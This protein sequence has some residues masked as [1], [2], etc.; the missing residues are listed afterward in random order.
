MGAVWLV[1][2]VELRRRWR[3][4]VILVILIAT[5]GGLVLAAAAA[6]RRTATAFPR[7]IAVHG[8]DVAAFN[9]R[10]RAAL[11]KLPEIASVTE[12]VSPSTGQPSCSCG[13]IDAQ[14]F[15]VVE[16]S[17]R[18]MHRA[19]KLEA[20]RWP[21]QSKPD[22]ALATYPLAQDLGV[23][24]GSVIRVPFYA[25][26]QSDAIDA[27]GE[28]P[29]PTGPKVSLRVVGIEAAEVD[30]PAGGTPSYS[31]YA[32]LS[33]AA[34]LTPLTV[35][36]TIDLVR[37][38]HGEGDL[39]RFNADAQPLVAGTL[40]LDAAAANVESSI[41]PQAVGWWVL[42][43]LVAM[44]GVA[45][46][47]QAIGRQSIVESEMYGTLL[48][49]GLPPRRLV[50]L[51]AVRALT[52]AL[53]GAVGAIVVAVALSPATPLG[54]ARVAEPSTGLAFDSLVL[55][56]GALS[57]VIVVIVLAVGPSIRAA[58]LRYVEERDPKLR[59][60]TDRHPA[61]GAGLAAFGDR[62]CASRT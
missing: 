35:T 42:A 4:W 22:E 46:V 6:G 55:L 10:S 24:V 28:L 56:L 57:I 34:K 18:A 13:R 37:L 21:D 25:A 62:R 54:E 51:V 7:F 60:S 31:L 20:G 36:N 26:S 48:A 11:V 14:E 12:S 40:N 52:V 29:S 39:P 32:T 58:R 59:P 23:H 16:M 61:C 33:L 19:L 47:G 38:R 50:A 17:S 49:L 43:A 3:S 53:V 15:G 8:Y 41:H 45:I 27:G 9:P 44:A 2:G 5:V 30:F 1:F